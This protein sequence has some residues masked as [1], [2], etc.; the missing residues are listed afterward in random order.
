MWNSH[1]WIHWDRYNDVCKH[2]YIV[3]RIYAYKRDAGTLTHACVL[4]CLF[5]SENKF[6]SFR[7]CLKMWCLVNLL[8]FIAAH[9][10]TCFCCCYSYCLWLVYGIAKQRRQ[11]TYVDWCWISQIL[12][13]FV[14][15]HIFFVVVCLYFFLC[16]LIY[17]QKSYKYFYFTL[18]YVN[19]R[20]CVFVFKLHKF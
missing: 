4:F 13:S 17:E 2:F 20:V 18:M 1:T 16:S 8:R 15:L 9:F 3:A 12:S 14:L 19:V 11:E 6:L 5:M 7:F 10:S